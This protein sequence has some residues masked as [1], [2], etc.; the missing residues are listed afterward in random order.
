[1]FHTHKTKKKGNQVRF[2]VT[3]PSWICTTEG[4][5]GMRVTSQVCGENRCVLMAGQ[6]RKDPK[7]LLFLI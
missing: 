7:E 5:L 3:S 1:M 4:I 6:K 2:E